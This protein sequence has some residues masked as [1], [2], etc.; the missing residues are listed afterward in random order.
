MNMIPII[1]ERELDKTYLNLILS[2]K[3]LDNENDNDSHKIL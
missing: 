1:N 2:L 3:K